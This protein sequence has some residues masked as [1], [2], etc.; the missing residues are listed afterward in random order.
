MNYKHE[1]K[2]WVGLFEP[3]FFGLKKHEFRVMDRDFA[4]GDVCRVREYEPTTKVY[5]GRELF[6]EI[7]YITSSQHNHCAFSPNA[8]HPGMAVLSVKVL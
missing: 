7:T 8:L 6:Y 3:L 2:S 5:T 4:V 1:L